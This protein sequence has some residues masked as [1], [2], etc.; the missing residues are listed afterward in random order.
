MCGV[1]PSFLSGIPRRYRLRDRVGRCRRI[2]R[3]RCD[4]S[5]LTTANPRSLDSCFATP[6]G[7][8]PIPWAPGQGYFG[9]LNLVCRSLGYVVTYRPAWRAS[10]GQNWPF[11][12]RLDLG[13]HGRVRLRV[14]GVE[15]QR[16]RK[17]SPRGSQ[18]HG[19]YPLEPPPQD[20]AVSAVFRWIRTAC[21]R[22]QKSPESPRMNPPQWQ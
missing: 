14:L 3:A 16:P 4:R 7:R 15:A 2:D 13:C 9:D 18:S 12:R 22:G 6:G 20:Q 11:V 10:S 5:G 19:C 8:Q 1:V 17:P 21:R